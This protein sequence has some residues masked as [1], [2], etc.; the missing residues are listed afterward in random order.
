VASEVHAIGG[1]VFAASRGTE[2]DGRKK[3]LYS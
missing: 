2:D 3:L 1:G